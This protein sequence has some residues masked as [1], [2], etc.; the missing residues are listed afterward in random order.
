MIR[1]SRSWIPWVFYCKFDA[2]F[3]NTFSLEYIWTAASHWFF[4]VNSVQ[5]QE[6]TDQK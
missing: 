2:Y 1:C 4:F 6:N 3:Q 5:I